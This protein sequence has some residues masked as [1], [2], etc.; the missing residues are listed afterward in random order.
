M[1]QKMLRWKLQQKSKS[2][3]K[4][5]LKICAAVSGISGAVILASVLLPI[6]Q[7]EAEARQK[8]PALLDPI[9]QKGSQS[10][11]GASSQD[12]DYTRASNWFVG[13]A[14]RQ[15]FVSGDI[16]FYTLSIPALGIE[17]AT[18]AIGGEDLSDSLI[19]YPGTAPPGKTGN[20]VI[21]GHSIL[22]QFFD[23]NNYLAIFSTLPNLKKGNEIYVN[24]DGISY[25]YRVEN[26]F[27]VKPADIQVLE[28]STSDSY[29]SLIT[30]TPP[31]HPL[32]PKRLI[33]RARIVPTSGASD[34]TRFANENTRY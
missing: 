9:V 33:I 7:Y 8:Y 13:G 24:Y 32:K 25:K 22:P 29:L 28:Q 15:D 18:V 10:E 19:Q 4:K 23:P 6:A 31:G 27:E 5:I 11:A 14:K 3:N 26:L 16:S 20:A 12:L 17:A 21:F 1:L 30:C 34:T 2:M